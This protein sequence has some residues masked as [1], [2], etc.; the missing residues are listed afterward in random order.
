MDVVRTDRRTR[1]GRVDRWAARTVSDGHESPGADFHS[2]FVCSSLVSG[3]MM[4]TNDENGAA[5]GTAWMEPRPVEARRWG[6]MHRRFVRGV[7][8]ADRRVT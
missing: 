6:A 8:R 1:P 5:K 7:A 4:T 3:A 2:L